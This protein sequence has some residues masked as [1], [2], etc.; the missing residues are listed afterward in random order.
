MTEMDLSQAEADALLSMEKHRVDDAVWNFPQPGQKIAIPLLS[1]DKREGFVLD[2][3]RGSIKLTKATLQHRARQALVLLRLDIEGAPHRNPDG[4]EIPCPHL[5]IYREGYGDRCAI[6]APRELI[7]AA[8]S[9]DQ[10]LVSF[11][12][13]CN[14]TRLPIVQGGLL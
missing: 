1:F 7:G 12:Q 6:A 9:L 14:V 5:H 4:E 13:R 10:I 3:A 8:D 11:M 2:V